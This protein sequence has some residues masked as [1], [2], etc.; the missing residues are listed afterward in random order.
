M[1]LSGSPSRQLGGGGGAK[2]TFGGGSSLF[3]MPRSISFKTLNTKSDEEFGL[4]CPNEPTLRRRVTIACG[5]ISCFVCTGAIAAV[6]SHA[7][8]PGGGGAPS[9]FVDVMDSGNPLLIPMNSSTGGHAYV[10]KDTTIADDASTK[11]KGTFLVLGDWGFDDK[12]HGNLNGGACQQAIADLMLATMRRL[13]DVKFIVNLGDSF[14]PDGVSGKDDPQWDRKW[15]NVY[16]QELRNVPW[17]SVY[18]NHDYHNDPG[19]CSMDAS[20]GA[21]VNDDINNLNHFY[22][23]AYNWFKQ[24]PEL[25]MEVV[26]LDFNAF[27]SGNG[28]SDC[29]YSDCVET[30][31]KN[32]ADRTE[33]GMDLFFTRAAESK[34]KNLLVFSHY[35]TDY[36]GSAPSFLDALRDGSKHNINYFGGHRHNVDQDSTLSISPNNNWLVGGGGG[37]SCDIHNGEN[38]QGFVV[39][40]IDLDSKVTTYPVI[41]DPFICCR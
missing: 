31:W 4:E 3:P 8:N 28:M 33:E 23:P 5:L 36:F 29:Q 14:Y 16:A 12:V 22:M 38:Y 27:E 15:R 2:L 37:W 18:G 21:L 39:G 40:E 25:D 7:V 17:Y 1:A 20:H 34:M 26:A 24:H 6:V 35:P 32:M 41:V 30:C 9:G 13:G 11:R 19:A 10:P